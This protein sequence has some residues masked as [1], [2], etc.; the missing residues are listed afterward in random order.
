[1]RAASLRADTNRDG[2]SR[3]VMENVDE[4]QVE[5]T[6]P[7]RGIFA[8]SCLCEPLSAAYNESVTLRLASVFRHRRFSGPSIRVVKRH[9]A[10][11]ASFDKMGRTMK[12]ES[13]V[14]IALP[15]TDL[16]EKGASIDKSSWQEESLG[17]LI[18]EEAALPFPL[19]AGPLF[20]GQIVL[21]GGSRGVNNDCASPDLRRLVGWMC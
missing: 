14:K 2:S 10:L 6:I 21:L 8:S 7:Q 12:V 3:I 1:M 16:S 4:H 11:R 18:A 19:K 17:K 9:D 15:V 13:D 20:R 5:S